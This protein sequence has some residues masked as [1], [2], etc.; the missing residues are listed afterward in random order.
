MA[1]GVGTSKFESGTYDTVDRWV[2]AGGLTGGVGAAGAAGAIGP[3][4]VGAGGG[5]GLGFVGGLI[6]NCTGCDVTPFG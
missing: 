4:G 6:S 3:P 2:S 5:V 1:A